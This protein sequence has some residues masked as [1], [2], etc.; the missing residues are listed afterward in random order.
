MDLLDAAERF[1]HLERER[2]IRLLALFGHNLTIA[3]R[4]TYE[5]QSP[6]VRA[7]ER[8]RAIN[9][10]QH[11]VTA[12]IAALTEQGAWRYDDETFFEMCLDH[13]DEHLRGQA[14]WAFDEAFKNVKM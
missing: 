9:E 14:G 10:I 2:Q 6:R 1:R 8:L 5:F 13:D 12:H 4:D 11:Q 7:P 3:A